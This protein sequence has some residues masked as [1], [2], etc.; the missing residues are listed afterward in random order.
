MVEPISEANDPRQSRLLGYIPAMHTVST[1]VAPLLAG[2]SV[3]LTGVVA[4]ASDRFRYPGATLLLLA[5]A[6]GAFV[7][8]VQ[9]GFWARSYLPTASETEGHHDAAP[10]RNEAQYDEWD[11]RTRLFYRI[12]LLLLLAGTA[13]LLLP[14]NSHPGDEQANWRLFGSF[15]VVAILVF[16]LFWISG[17]ALA[18]R[19]PR[20]LSDRIVL[21]ALNAWFEPTAMKARRDEYEGSRRELRKDDLYD[22]FKW[23]RE[24]IR[25]DLPR[26]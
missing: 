6:V 11:R 16:E 13:T 14:N 10:H 1:I 18:A 24:G 9:C 4:Q 20:L 3:T 25:G 19:Y 7:M 5:L 22:F 12:G 15:A 8:C 26:R 23:V 21:K 17:L 2:F